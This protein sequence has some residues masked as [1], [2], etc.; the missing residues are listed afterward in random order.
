[1]YGF[2]F[3]QKKLHFNYESV[4]VSGFYIIEAFG[5]GLREKGGGCLRVIGWTE[6]V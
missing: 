4:T 5:F 6:D 1:M 2:G 3:G